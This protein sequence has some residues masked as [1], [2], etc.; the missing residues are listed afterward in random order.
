VLVR[1]D[2]K[3]KGPKLEAAPPRVL[4]DP[5]GPAPQGTDRLA[6]AD[7]LTR[8]DHPLTARVLVNR[9][10][11]HHFGRGIVATPNDFG[12]HGDAPSHR[13]LLDW[14]ATEFVSRGWSI[15][16]LHRLMVLSAAYR[17][18]SRVDNAKARKLDPDNALLWR[19]NRRRLEGRTTHCCGG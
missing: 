18:E 10:W 7:W 14:L 19:M 15:K 13:E 11:Q 8:P 12:L 9:L 5:K 16:Q 17:Q 4:V 1:G 2:P 6:L 3:K